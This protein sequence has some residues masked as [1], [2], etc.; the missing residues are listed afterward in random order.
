MFRRS[1]VENAEF[2]L[3]GFTSIPV[4][5][6]QS[7]MSITSLSSPCSSMAPEVSLI[8]DGG[9]WVV[10]GNEGGDSTGRGSSIVPCCLERRKNSDNDIIKIK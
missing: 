2:N 5:F 4:E 7:S 6:R 8:G 1:A 10:K 3:A 9:F